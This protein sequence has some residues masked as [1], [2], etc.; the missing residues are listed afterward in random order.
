MTAAVDEVGDVAEQILR[1]FDL[2]AS[3]ADRRSLIVV[4]LDVYTRG[5]V[6]CSRLALSEM[7]QAREANR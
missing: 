4:L 3:E 1:A 6:R 5:F 7:R 2:E